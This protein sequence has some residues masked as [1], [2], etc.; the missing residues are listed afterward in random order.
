[1]ILLGSSYKRWVDVV[2]CS[3]SR[4]SESEQERIFG[5]TATEVYRL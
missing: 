5:K 4:L 3:I 1:V 2:Q